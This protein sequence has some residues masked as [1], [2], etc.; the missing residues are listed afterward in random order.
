MIPEILKNRYWDL[1]FSFI[2]RHCY[3]TGNNI[4][5]ELAYRGRKKIYT[6]T[7]GLYALNDDIWLCKKEYLYRLSNDQL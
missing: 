4:W 5:S 2:K 7:Q 3:I 6:I 1:R